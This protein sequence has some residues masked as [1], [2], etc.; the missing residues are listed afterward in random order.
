MA[1]ARIKTETVEK[2][3]TEEVDVGITLELT[4]DEAETLQIVGSL[5]GGMPEG[6]RGH[7]DSINT[8]LRGA[9]VYCLG[10][11]DVIGNSLTGGGRAAIYFGTEVTR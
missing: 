10:T 11:N 4:K 3:V 6:R 7:F 1:E 9:G 5:I 8:A 2:V